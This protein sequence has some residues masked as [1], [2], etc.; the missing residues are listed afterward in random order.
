MKLIKIGSSPSSDIVLNNEYVSAHHAEITVLDGGEIL[1][2]DKGSKNGT[3]V[4]VNKTRLEPG[5]EYA[6]NRGDRVMFGNEPLNW[7]KVPTPHTYN[8]ARRVVNIGSSPKNDLV[9]PGGVVSR[10]HATLIIDKN[11]KAS[12]IDNKSTNGTK[13]NGQ[14]IL[15]GRPTP[16]KRGDNVIVGEEDITNRLEDILPKKSSAGKIAGIAAAAVVCIGLVVAGILTWPWFTPKPVA[17]SDNSVLLVH[18]VYHYTLEL[19]DNPYKIPIKITTDNISSFGTGFFIDD[20]GRI[21]TNRHV[22]NPWEEEYQ[23][24][25]EYTK[26]NIHDM[27]KQLWEE[28]IKKVIPKRCDPND[29]ADVYMLTRTDEGKAIYRAYLANP[30]ATLNTMLEKVHNSPVKVGGESAGISVG[31]ANRH[32]TNTSEF[33]PAVMLAESGTKDKDV[34]IIQLNTQETPEKALKSG[35]FSMNNLNL[36]RPKIQS[37]T[38]EFKGYPGGLSRTFDEHFQSSTQSP[39]TYRGKVSR[40][41]DPFKFEIQANTTHGASGSPVYN[42]EGKLYGIVTGGHREGDD[43]I[44]TPAKFLKELYDQHVVKYDE[45]EQ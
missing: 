45:E 27:L 32:Y 3:Y 33:A 34:A 30:I 13:I 21:G 9:I 12:I 4:G 14:K 20:K 16:V 25:D 18:N 44:I 36:T 23:D 17:P 39:T 2:E 26:L 8:N 7:A 43:V 35:I 40:N 28:K 11:G 10:Y 41:S 15:A 24:E 1:I 5:K 29:Y 38:L 19:A 6:L 22:T 31:F 42:N 37:E